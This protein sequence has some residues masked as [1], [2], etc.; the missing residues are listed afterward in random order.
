MVVAQIA[1][2]EPEVLFGRGAEDLGRDPLAFTALVEE[3][4]PGAPD[5]VF[6][7]AHREADADKDA[8]EAYRGQ[9]VKLGFGRLGL[10]LP[11]LG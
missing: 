1:D 6:G 10:R 11:R 8:F 2:G 3:M 7:P 9:I 4:Q 5:A